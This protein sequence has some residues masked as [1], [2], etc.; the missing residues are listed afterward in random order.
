MPQQTEEKDQLCRQPQ[1]KI[2]SWMIKLFL[3]TNSFA[4]F[5]A[6]PSSHLPHSWTTDKLTGVNFNA[7][8]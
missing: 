7:I 2:Y 1:G 3:E 4:G 8:E 5:A 6:G